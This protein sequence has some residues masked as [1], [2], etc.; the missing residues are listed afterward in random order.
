LDLSTLLP[1]LDILDKVDHLAAASSFGG[2][3][4]LMAVLYV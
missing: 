1:Y 4:F 2:A 3:F